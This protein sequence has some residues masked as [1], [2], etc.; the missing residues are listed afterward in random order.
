[1]EKVPRFVRRNG[2]NGPSIVLVTKTP[3]GANKEFSMWELI[4]KYGAD[5]VLQMR[6]EFPETEE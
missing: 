1:M 3:D 6:Q 5:K 2:P 4:N